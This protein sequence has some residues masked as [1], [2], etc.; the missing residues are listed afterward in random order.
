MK[1]RMETELVNE[2]VNEILQFSRDT[3][4]ASE[5]LSF[6]VKREAWLGNSADHFWEQLSQIHEKLHLAAEESTK[7]CLSLSKEREQWEEV[8]NQGVYRLKN[9]IPPE[10]AKKDV[11]WWFTAKLGFGQI[12]DAV[13]NYKYNKDYQRFTQWWNNQSIDEKK[14]YLQDLQD[15]WADELGW[16]RMLVVADDLEDPLGGGDAQGL[17]IDG[18]LIV[19]IDNFDTDDP[20]RLMET[21]F[22][23]SRHQ[24]Q[25][26]AIANFLNSGQIP[27]GMKKSEIE[28]WAYEMKE[29]NYI[30]P[31]DDF[32]SYYN[33]AIEKDARKWGDIVMKDV[34][35]EMENDPWLNTGSG[36]GSW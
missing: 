20:W 11:P 15:R 36:G 35:D 33:Q 21:M 29:E 3:Y 5:S 31:S 22:H 17:N 34:L 23:E 9:S 13:E 1:I 10:K 4:A 16:P 28:Q 26:E 7:L 24:Y 12:A 14:A 25:R 30:P 27:D 32:E 19:D 2:L 18:I 6:L 8:D